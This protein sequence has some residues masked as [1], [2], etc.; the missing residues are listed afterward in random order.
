MRSLSRYAAIFSLAGAA[1]TAF[2]RFRQTALWSNKVQPAIADAG[3]RAASHPRVAAASG[4]VLPV[5][6]AATTRTAAARDLVATGAG[7]ARTLVQRGPVTGQVLADPDT[8]ATP[9]ATAN[10]GTATAYGRIPS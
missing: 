7:R 10:G 5:L 2:Q 9:A 6:D 8:E 1:Y 4:R 3:S